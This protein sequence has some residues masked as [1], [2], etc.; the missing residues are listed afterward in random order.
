MSGAEICLEQTAF[1][2]FEAADG[3]LF[4][5]AHTFA[6]QVEFGSDFLKCHL[7]AAY[8]EEHFQDFALALVELLECAVHFVAELFAVEAGVGHGRIV[9]CQ[10]VQQAVVLTLYEGGV[11]RDVASAHLQ[12]VG[13]LVYRD[14]EGF[15]ELLG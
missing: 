11:H 7:L 3:L 10:H 12:R 13:N 8:A 9:V 6:R 1:L 4:D 5:L 15:G 2:P 14:I